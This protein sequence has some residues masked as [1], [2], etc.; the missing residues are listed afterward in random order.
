M[1]S[2]HCL[3]SRVCLWACRLYSRL[4][5]DHPLVPLEIKPARVQ[6]GSFG[7]FEAKGTS[8]NVP[9]PQN[10]LPATTPSEYQVLSVQPN[11]EAAAL[12]Q[13]LLINRAYRNFLKAQLESIERALQQNAQ[14]QE[15]FRRL[16]QRENAPAPHRRRLGQRILF[17]VDEE[18][19]TPPENADTIRKRPVREKMPLTHQVLQ[20]TPA[21]RV[22]LAAGV[23]DQNRQ[24]LLDAAVKRCREAGETEEAGLLPPPSA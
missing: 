15:K 13:L 20:W 1:K 16:I 22:E 4:E 7:S 8:F 10:S 3:Y 17:F 2:K 6:P 24:R 21:E 5:N 14:Y 23:R 18:G 11:S 9:P 19:D 12:R